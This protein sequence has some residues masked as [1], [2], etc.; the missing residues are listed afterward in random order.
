MA[1]R[2]LSGVACWLATLSTLSSEHTSGSMSGLLDHCSAVQDGAPGTCIGALRFVDFGPI[3]LIQELDAVDDEA[4]FMCAFKGVH[5]MLFSISVELYLVCLLPCRMHSTCLMD[6]V[7][8]FWIA[9]PGLMMN[10]EI[11]PADIAFS[12]LQKMARCGA[13]VEQVRTQPPMLEHLHGQHPD[14][15]ITSLCI[16][17]NAL[18]PESSADICQSFSD[19]CQSHTLR[20][21]L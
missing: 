9:I 16:V 21:I 2:R 1:G 11:P 17:V 13:S 5:A 12:Y 3:R 19:K 18:G 6:L 10:M 15:K 8:W 4:H 20:H 14:V 7:I